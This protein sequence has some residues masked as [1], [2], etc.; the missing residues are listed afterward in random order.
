MGPNNACRHFTY[1]RFGRLFVYN[2]NTTLS[3]DIRVWGYLAQGRK[4]T[5]TIDFTSSCIDI[6]VCA[7]PTGMHG[8]DTCSYHI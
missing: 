6:L 1:H 3:Q 2:C 8:E 5:F 4:F 7:L